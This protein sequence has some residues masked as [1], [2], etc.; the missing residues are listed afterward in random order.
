MANVVRMSSDRDRIPALDGLRGIAILLVLL[1]HFWLPVDNAGPF[2]RCLSVASLGGYVGVDLFFVL[3]GF[4]ITGVLLDAKRAARPHAYR[5]F[6]V[7]RALRILPLY[8]GVVAALILR[9]PSGGLH[10]VQW[11][12]WLHLTNVG[13][14]LVRPWY[15]P[16]HLWSLAIEEQFY[17]VWP[18]VVLGLSERRLLQVCAACAVIALAC[19][20]AMVGAGLDDRLIYVMPFTRMDT[21]VAGGALAVLARGPRGLA[22]YMPHAK[23]WGPVAALIFVG[24]FAMQQGLGRWDPAF[25]TIGYSAAVV[26]FASTLVLTVAGPLERPLSHPV[27]RFFGVYSYGIYVLHEIL[28]GHMQ[29]LMIIATRVPRVFGSA[30]GGDLFF[31]ASA[32]SLSVAAAFVS[33]HCYEKPFLALK[34]FVP[35]APSTVVSIRERPEPIPLGHQRRTGLIADQPRVLALELDDR[36]LAR[37]DVKQ[38]TDFGI[39]PLGID[40]QRIDAA[41]P[42]LPR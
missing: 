28:F 35:V 3:S 5:T 12:Y 14:A 32:T 22:A 23:R 38:P 17:L 9:H 15:G 19:R 39:V 40:L 25:R 7:R 33:W 26:L 41:E 36:G 37:R 24:L 18:F 1:R 11:W 29:P 13:D 16:G 30:I 27:L 34:R 20:A 21:L 4:L 31:F 6:Y 8:Y 2:D 10:Q 42:D